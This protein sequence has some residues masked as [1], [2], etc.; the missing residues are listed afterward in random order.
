[1]QVFK[2]FSFTNFRQG[3]LLQKAE[4]EAQ[5]LLAQERKEIEMDLRQVKIG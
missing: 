2:K 1:L 5:K 3:L 4:Q